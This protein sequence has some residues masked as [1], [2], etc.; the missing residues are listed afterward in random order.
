MGLDFLVGKQQM[1][2]DLRD[3]EHAL[4]ANKS[5]ALLT[6]PKLDRA[7]GW[8]L[9]R[10]HQLT[11]NE[12]AFVQASIDHADAAER[13]KMRFRRNLTW[14]SLSAALVLAFVAGLAGWQ[15]RETQKAFEQVS[16]EGFHIF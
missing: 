6:G 8:M 10:A 1:E 3:W 2:I 11:A 14:A 7:R 5:G 16:S 4:D 12:S 15:W 13:R 9:E